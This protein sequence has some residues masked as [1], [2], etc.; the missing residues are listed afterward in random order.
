MTETENLMI[1][2]IK[3]ISNIINDYYANEIG[4]LPKEN[5]SFSIS[6]IF[7]KHQA[8][9]AVP[10]A[11][12]KHCTIF[13]KLPNVNDSQKIAYQYSHE[14]FHVYQFLFWDSP[15]HWE[16]WPRTK[17]LDE[18]YA[19]AASIATLLNV[20]LPSIALNRS[21]TREEMHR[22]LDG[23]I[24]GIVKNLQSGDDYTERRHRQY[25]QGY[26]VA[27]R[28]NYSLPNIVNQ[29]LSDTDARPILQAI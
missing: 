24:P 18:K 3:I 19:Q 21:F 4:I 20:E 28:A 5:G 16:G 12:E 6:N 14:L 1:N 11:N 15:N 29:Y 27:A 9:I 17:L 22:Y 7:D 13:L 2:R 23:C 8:P 25:L 26:D 10:M